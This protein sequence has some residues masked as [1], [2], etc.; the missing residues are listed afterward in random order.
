[1]ADWKL[2]EGLRHFFGIIKSSS[3]AMT[4]LVLAVRPAQGSWR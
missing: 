4:L 1:M 3:R 2:N